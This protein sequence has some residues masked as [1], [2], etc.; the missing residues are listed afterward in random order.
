[1]LL[2]LLAALAPPTFEVRER[3]DLP[4]EGAKDGTWARPAFDKARF[5]LYVPQRDRVLIVDLK[6]GKVV[7]QATGIPEVGAVALAPDRDLGFVP[8]G[9][10]VV[11]FDATNGAEVKRIPMPAEPSDLV[12]DPR[13]RRVLVV[14]R[15]AKT[16]T[17]I[18][19]QGL[20]PE[21]SI[22][23]GGAPRGIVADGW[24]AALIAE[25][26]AIERIDLGKRRVASRWDVKATSLAYDDRRKLLFAHAEGAPLSIL[27]AR[28]GTTR[29][30]LD[31]GPGLR[32][33]L[34]DHELGLVFGL[35]LD[36]KL[37]VVHAKSATVV[38]TLDTAPTALEAAID[39]DDHRLYLV[40]LGTQV[41]VVARAKGQ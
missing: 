4:T 13:T 9:S 24:G 39:P 17:P 15:T 8:S 20:V 21:A 5:R 29:A 18:D 10:N 26:D 23:L 33:L 7:A 11:V 2:P 41:I 16:L 22:P 37:T 36:G 1:M 14:S 32:T 6:G 40:N 19:P 35:G 25:G 27:D 31:L 38:Q 12:Y 34:A 30:T 3:I 28:K